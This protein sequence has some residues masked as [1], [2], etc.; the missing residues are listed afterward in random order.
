MK[1]LSLIRLTGGYVWEQGK[2]PC[3]D[4]LRLEIRHLIE[5]DILHTTVETQ[6]Q[7]D[8]QKMKLQWERV[9]ASGSVMFDV[10]HSL[11]ILQHAF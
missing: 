5:H 3:Y 7:H 10:S 11:V 1:A 2:V 8:V 4:N 6:Q 9:L